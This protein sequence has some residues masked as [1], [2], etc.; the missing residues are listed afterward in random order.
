MKL[1]SQP[2]KTKGA[3]KKLKPTLNDNSTTQSPSYCEHV[4][5]RFPDS[6]TSKSQKP[7]KMSNKGA[8]ISKPPPTPIPLKIPIIEE[9][10]IPPNIL[11]I[12]EMPVFMHPYIKRIVDIAGDGNYDYR[13]VSALLGNGEGSH[14]VFRHQ[15]IQDLKT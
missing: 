4:D 14:T 10:P 1:S 7:Q 11:F 9:M 6:P 13:V 15:L 2:I 12:E 8:R 5:K 3:P